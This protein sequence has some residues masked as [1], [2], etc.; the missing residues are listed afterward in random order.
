MTVDQHTSRKSAVEISEFIR[1]L[2]EDPDYRGQ[3]VHVERLH[4]RSARYG[5][6]SRA[7]PNHLLAALHD[8]GIERLYAH[9]ADAI[10]AI[11]ERRDVMVS[12]STASGKTLCYHIPTLESWLDDPISK[13]LYLFPTKALSQDQRRTLQ[14][15]TRGYLKGIRFGTYDGD[16]SRSARG[17]LRRTAAIILTNPDMLH[18]GILPNHNLWAHFLSHL[19]YVVVD[20][21]HAYRG[22]FGSHVACVLRRLRRLCALYGASPLFICC[23]ATIA[24]PDEHAERLLGLPVTVIDCDGSPQAEKLFALWN[25]PFVDRAKTARRSPNTEATTLFTELVQHGLRN[26][27]FT[28][29]RRVTELIL[30]YARDTLRRKSPELLDRIASYR[31]GYQP[32]ERR[33]VEKA[34]FQGELLGVTATN[35]LELGVDVGSLEATIQVGYPGTI[36]SLWQQ[37]GRAGRGARPSVSFLIG[38]D[39]P[40]DQYFMRHPKEL[41]GRSHEHALIDPSNIYVLQKHLPCAAH[42]HPLTN[43][44]EYLFGPGFPEAMALLERRGVLEYRGQRWF[45]PFN[46]Y[47]AQDVSIR[48]FSANNFVL[49]DETDNFRILEEVEETAAFFRIHPGAIY[50]HR[51]RAYLITHLDLDVRV[52]RAR[53]ADPDYYTL[54]RELDEIQVIG[55]WQAT[56]LAATV[57]HFGQVRVSQQVVGYRRIQQFTERLLGVEHLDLPEQSFETHALWFEVPRGIAAAAGRRGLDFDGGLHAVEHAMIGMLPLF[58]MCDRMDIGGLSTPSHPD[59]GRAAIFVY[60]ALPGGVGISEKGFRLLPSLWQAALSVIAECPCQEGCPSCVQSPKCGSNNEPLDKEAAI[61]ILRHL[62]K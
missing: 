24:N 16:T 39:N 53:P 10:N 23:S 9:Q 40:L 12:T 13:A 52:A 51:G 25:P 62:L 31:G 46:D 44:D 17:R 37:A 38:H 60:D 11:R 18:A 26:I 41:F 4:A 5:K 7:L 30:T 43:D 2:R 15:L 57:A 34:L 28:K 56:S 27:T 3:I 1:H 29:S 49:V 54:A 8:R 58:A 36:A 35:A 47:P 19:T 45:F 21:A 14:E 33:R 55:S 32:E 48:S 6:L 59:T 20:E 50:L 61:V 22:V 42:E